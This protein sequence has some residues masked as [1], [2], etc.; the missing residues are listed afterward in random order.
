MLS[1][2]K[3]EWIKRS[4]SAWKSNA[5]PNALAQHFRW[6]EQSVANAQESYGEKADQTTFYLRL[7]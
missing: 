4:I 7:S 3:N 2:Q 5:P 6:L 1:S